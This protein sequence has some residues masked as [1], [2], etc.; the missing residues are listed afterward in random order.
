MGA[1]RRFSILL[2]GFGCDVG[3]DA[4]VGG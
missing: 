4:W 2:A 1:G 3:I